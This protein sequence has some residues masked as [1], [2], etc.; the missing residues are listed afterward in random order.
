MSRRTLLFLAC[1]AACDAKRP[2]PPAPPSPAPAEPVAAAPPRQ[3]R[4]VTYDHILITFKG[5]HKRVSS[6]LT[7]EQAEALAKSLFERLEAGVVDWNAAKAEY[8][9]DRGMKT[10]APLGPYVMVNDGV[11][12]AAGEIPRANAA[13]GL[14]DLVFFLKVGEIGL[15]EYDPKTSEYGWHIVKRIE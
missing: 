3:P 13:R 14:G 9:A 15:V 11:Q 1:V 5:A 10:G 12:Y 6:S 8:T 2:A 7:R 4:R